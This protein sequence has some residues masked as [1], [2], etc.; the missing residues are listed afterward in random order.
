[1]DRQSAAD[2]LRK[3]PHPVSEEE[4]RNKSAARRFYEEVWN[5]GNLALAGELVTPQQR[6]HDPNNPNAAP[7]PEGVR[8]VVSF[9][10]NAFPDLRLRLE[11]V[12]SEGDRVVLRISASGTHQRDLPGIAATGKRIEMHGIVI[13]RYQDGR[14]AE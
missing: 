3:D 9:Y 8:Q 6:M 5:K 7:G 13:H 14:S 10:R 1:M 11:D 12:V 2:R 4:T